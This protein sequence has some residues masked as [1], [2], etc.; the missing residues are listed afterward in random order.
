MLEAYSTNQT[1][2]NGGVL[3]F[4][5]VSLKKGKTATLNGVSSIELNTSGVYEI[6]LNLS[7][8]PTSSGDV[9]INM[10]KDG[11]TQA[12]SSIDISTVVTTQGVHGTVSTL[13]QVS[14]NNGACCCSSPTVIQFINNG[15][16]LTNANMNVVVTKLC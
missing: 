8:L 1:I 12:Q 10:A 13:V 14:K 9:V 2:I 15:V 11:V 5:S 6:I 16:G 4:N 7:A 3:P